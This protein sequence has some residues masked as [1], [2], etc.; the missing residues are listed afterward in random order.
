MLHPDGVRSDGALTL[1]SNV[2]EGEQL[3]L[4]IGTQ[5]SL[6]ERAGEVAQSA[7][8]MHS[9]SKSEIAGALVTYC[10]GCML[11]VKEQ[12]AEVVGGLNR[13]LDGAPFLGN[14]T[15]GEQ[16]CFSDYTNRHANLMISALVF[17]SRTR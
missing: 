8:G 11:T 12:M 16:G 17:T 15:F 7:L 5:A 3:T 14:F 10:A 13:A 4:M 1:F 6:I 2:Q 9:L